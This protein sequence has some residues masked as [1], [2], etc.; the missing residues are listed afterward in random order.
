M[1]HAFDKWPELEFP[2]VEFER[3]ADDAVVHCATEQQA[4]RVLAALEERMVRGRAA[5]APRQDQDRVLQGMGEEVRAR[6]IHSRSGTELEDIAS[7]VNPLIPGLDDLLVR[8]E[9]LLLRMEVKDRP[10]PR[11]RSGGVKLEAA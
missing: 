3:Y 11:C 5:T 7:W 8:H 9:A 10:S 1:H 6:R 2:A 4:R